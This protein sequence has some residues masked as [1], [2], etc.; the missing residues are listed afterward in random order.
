[1]K[2]EKKTIVFSQSVWRL[3]IGFILATSGIVAIFIS[4]SFKSNIALISGIGFV[5]FICGGAL[6]YKLF[7]S[8][9]SEET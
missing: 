4:P 2:K 1:M 5:C 8:I 6:T 3:I 7:V 9:D